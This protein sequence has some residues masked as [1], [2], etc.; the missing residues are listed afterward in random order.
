MTPFRR[1]VLVGAVGSA[2]LCVASIVAA[3]GTALA[4]AFAEELVD[5]DTTEEH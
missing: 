2:A 1:G 4:L 5:D 3:V